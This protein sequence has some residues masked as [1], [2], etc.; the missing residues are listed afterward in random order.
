[1]AAT[2]APT[3]GGVPAPI[4]FPLNFRKAADHP[5][6]NYPETGLEEINGDLPEADFWPAS[7]K[8]VPKHNF[9]LARQPPRMTIDVKYE[10]DSPAG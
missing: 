7:L 2:G 1:M 3:L 5:V 10:L 8:F 4:C 9:R 6:V